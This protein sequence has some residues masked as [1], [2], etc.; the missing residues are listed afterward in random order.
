MRTWP[1]LPLSNVLLFPSLSVIFSSIR[2]TLTERGLCPEYLLKEKISQQQMCPVREGSQSDSRIR[3]LEGFCFGNSRDFLQYLQRPRQCLG[4]L[5]SVSGFKTSYW[6]PKSPHAHMQSGRGRGLQR[7]AGPKSA[8]EWTEETPL[9]VVRCSR[10]LL[11]RSSPRFALSAGTFQNLVE[12][13]NCG[14]PILA[15][16]KACDSGA[17]VPR[18]VHQRAH[19][20]HP[21]G[22]GGTSHQ[23]KSD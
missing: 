21:C 16:H 10:A 11:S 7:Q 6:P 8:A 9:A 2:Q 1:L 20:P 3:N 13:G 12:N 15:L 18:C 22:F 4:D 14:T 17:V 19:R 23:H 5:E